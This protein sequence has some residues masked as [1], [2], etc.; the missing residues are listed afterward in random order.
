M[1]ELWFSQLLEI[2]GEWEGYEKS[3]NETLDLFI[4]IYKSKERDKF[5][6]DSYWDKL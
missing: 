3:S 6:N 1:F 2:V 5:L 4:D